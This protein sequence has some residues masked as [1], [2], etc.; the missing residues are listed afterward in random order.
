MNIYK[1]KYLSILGDSISAL[2]GYIPKGFHSLYSL[3]TYQF[4]GINKPEDTWWGQVIEHFEFKLLVNN[5]GF[6][7]RACIDT[8]CCPAEYSTCSDTRT[9]NLGKDGIMPDHIIVFIGDSDIGS[10]AKLTSEDKTDLSVF[11]NAYQVMISKIK[12]NYPNAEIW[13]CTFPITSWTYPPHSPNY[14]PYSLPHQPSEEVKK[15]ICDYGNCVKNLAQH[16]G[17][18]IIDLMDENALCDAIFTSLPTVEGMK[19]IAAKVIATMEE[20]QKNMG[21]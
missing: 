18:H 20:V 1:N 4:M 17:C 14:Q 6:A 15:V 7:S 21:N 5:S 9:G 10:R 13:C 11:E 8:G 3:K 19:T 16:N 12:H 2:D